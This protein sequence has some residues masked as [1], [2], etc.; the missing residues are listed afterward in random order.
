MDERQLRILRELG[1]LGSVTAVAEA[2]LVTP[3][4]ISQQ[5]RLLQRSIPVP[6]TERQGRRLVLTDAGQ[7]LAGSAIEVE[8]ALERARRSVGEFLDRPDGEVSVAAFHSAAATFFPVLLLAL[9]GPGT[10]VPRLADEDVP[11]E[12]FPRLTREYDLVLAHRLDHAA[13]WPDT[14]TAT[15]LLREPL[16]VAMPAGHPLAAK[17][18]VTP[19][20]VAAE[21]WITVH[22]GFPVLATV[23]AIAAAAGRRLHLAHRIN[24]FA[25]A[26]EA[27]AAGGGLALMPRW[28]TRPHPA[29]VLK[30]L[31][32]VQARRH[33]DA[34]HRPERTARTAVRTVLKELQEAARTIRAR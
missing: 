13:P 1:E 7:T 6:L 32:G 21:P 19:R 31:S 16:D 11:Q 2:L 30:P 24:D 34:L 18:R 9:A 28:T 20:D 27:V 17:R 23:E 5:L 15:T 4:A 33:I 29:L 12:D 25:V 10:P 14:V 8:S 3:S 22:D 26:A